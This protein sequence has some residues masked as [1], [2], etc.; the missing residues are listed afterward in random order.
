MA[1]NLKMYIDGAWV[2]ARS[3]DTFESIDP[4]TGQVLAS[5]PRGGNRFFFI[6]SFCEFSA[7]SLTPTDSS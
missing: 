4:A 1:E 7:W 2:E 3:G 6:P 5:V